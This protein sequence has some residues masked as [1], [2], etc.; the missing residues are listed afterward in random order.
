MWDKNCDFNGNS[1]LYQASTAE[2]C[3][4]HCIKND[5]C[6][7]MVHK[8]GIC[9]LKDYGIGYTPDPRPGA[10]CG[11]VPNRLLPGRRLYL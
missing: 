9:Q 8:E 2:E 10:Y 7:Y 5:R 1:F 11:Y 4:K 6:T 3:G